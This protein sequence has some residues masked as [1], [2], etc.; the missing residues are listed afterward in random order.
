MSAADP[1]RPD[2]WDPSLPRWARLANLPFIAGVWF[3]RVTLSRLTGRYCRFTPT[4]SQ[5]ALDA[6]H[7][8]PP[9]RATRLTLWRL[10]RC[11]PLARG[12]YDPVPLPGTVP[13]ARPDPS[14]NAP[15]G[16]SP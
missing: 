3:Y 15:P 11:Q 16:E 1:A 2:P 6:Y 4:C 5:Y 10:A 9:I 12:G 13:V 7:T 8:H 14:E